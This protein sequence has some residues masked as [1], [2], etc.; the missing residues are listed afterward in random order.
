[1]YVIRSKEDEVYIGHT[2]NI[3]RRLEQ[4]NSHSSF[5]TK[6]GKEWALIHWEEHLDRASAVKRE[7]FLKTGDGRRVLKIK[8]VL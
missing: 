2:D 6:I 3:E 7:S 4:H 5:A 8:K 1:V